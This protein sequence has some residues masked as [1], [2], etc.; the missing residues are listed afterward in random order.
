VST[1]PQ[2]EIGSEFIGYRIEE[3]IGQGGMGVVYRSYD[4]RL[5]RGV[6]LK[7][8]APELAL[9]DRFRDRFACE[10]EVAMSL[11]HPNVVP[12]YDAGDID[13]RLYLAMRHVEGTDLRALLRREGPLEPAHALAICGQVGAA[14]DAAHARGLVHRD[15]K[16]SNV[17]LDQDEHVYL[18]DFGLSRRLAEQAVDAGEGRSVGTPAYVAPEQIEGKL[19]DGRAD[20]YSLGCLLYECLTGE[21]PFSHGSRLAIA[22][23]HLEEEPP[24]ASE[25]N[26]SLPSA[27][28][29]VIRQAMAK[30]PE[31]RF[32]TCT[33]LIRAAEEVLGIREPWMLRRRRLA[34]VSAAVLVALA[35][36]FA[37]ALFARGGGRTVSTPLVRENTIVRIDPT[38]DSISDVIDVGLGPSAVAVAGRNV[39]VYNHYDHTVTQ[40][41]AR[42]TEVRQTA[43]VSAAPVDLGLLTGPVLA[44][45]ARGAWLVGVDER[46]RSRLVRVLA[47]GGGTRTY[48]LDHEPRAVA[49]GENAVWVLAR[50]TREHQLLRIDPATG[51]VT[52]RTRFRASPGIDS[53]DVGLGAVWVV[54]SSSAV[55]YRIDPRS[56]TK[57][58]QID[59]GRR[60]GRPNVRFGAVWVGVSDYGL[61]TLV[62]D[63]RRL[64]FT[65]LGCCPLR[66]G[67][68]TA[69]GYGSIWYFDRS[70]GTVVRWD[71]QTKQIASSIPVAA[72]PVW[73]GPCL[74]SVA[75]GADGVWVTVAPSRG[76][77]CQV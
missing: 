7:L 74:T 66:D 29:G 18:A 47:R 70:T 22:W 17:L 3:V 60:A 16:P 13:G 8:V 58:G 30:L 25:R 39:W 57:T 36:S 61:G 77:T 27:I 9:D 49:V 19:V 38:T 73:G 59:L 67:Y 26:P 32:P 63:P 72:P 64:T 75:A 15:V 51:K 6:A 56:A 5:K 42:T 76:S 71:G 1:Q 68:E 52:A 62:V 12:I 40:I 4:L 20:V 34:V 44:A 65:A 43:A 37:V 23:A 10:S 55:L 31:E 35:A 41:D 33:A 46:G 69:T 11:E 24:R 45:D 50:G 54:S 48:L 14:L 21:T 53:L 2:I 28:D